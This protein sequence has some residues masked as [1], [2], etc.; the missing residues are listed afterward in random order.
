[1]TLWLLHLHAL[2]AART[3]RL[4][5][6]T[7]DV[8]DLVGFWVEGWTVEQVAAELMGEDAANA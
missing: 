1:M 7:G 8:A 4:D 5:A 3:G 2:L 6:W